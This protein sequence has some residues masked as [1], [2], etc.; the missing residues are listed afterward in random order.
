MELPALPPALD[1]DELYLLQEDKE[2][3]DSYLESSVRTGIGAQVQALRE[4]RHLTQRDL[5]SLTGTTQSSISRLE[6]ERY[7]RVNVQTLLSIA[8]ATDTALIIRFAPYEE[9]LQF[10]K[11]LSP[12]ALQ[13]PTISESIERI[14]THQK[15]IQ[16]FNSPNAIFQTLIPPTKTRTGVFAAVGGYISTGIINPASVAT[17][18]GPQRDS[19]T[20]LSQNIGEQ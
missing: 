5:A 11:S 16:F 8:K 6:D 17:I 18:D 7:G 13:V 2:Y 20:I 19:G 4:Q 15:V 10:A 9:F 3:R 14:E 12:A 1:L